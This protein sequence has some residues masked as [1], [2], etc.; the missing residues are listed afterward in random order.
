MINAFFYLAGRRRRRRTS[1]SRP[2][3]SESNN[4][5]G[6]KLTTF[7]RFDAWPNLTWPFAV[8]RQICGK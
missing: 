3:P 4:G 5:N 7:A 6:R 8:V 2:V 1:S